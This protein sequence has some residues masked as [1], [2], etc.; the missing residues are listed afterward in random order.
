ME[1][2][3]HENRSLKLVGGN[4]DEKTLA[5]HRYAEELTASFRRY[6]SGTGQP[7]RPGMLVQWKPGMKNRK[8]PEYGMPM[9]VVQVLEQPI[10]DTSFDSGSVYFRERLDIILGFLD[11]DDDFCMIHYDSRRFEPHAGVGMEQAARDPE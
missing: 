2:T 9:I 11:A 3:T 7:L 1:N 5:M 10:I 8:T 4:P 6:T